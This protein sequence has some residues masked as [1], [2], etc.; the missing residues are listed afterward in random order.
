[1]FC[2]GPKR[3]DMFA[4]CIFILLKH[5][6]A[7]QKHVHT[8]DPHYWNARSLWYCRNHASIWDHSMENYDWPAA[9][10]RL[11]LL[12]LK[13]RSEC[14]KNG[15]SLPEN[16]F[17]LVLAGTVFFWHGLFFMSVGFSCD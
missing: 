1:M 15:S 16:S 10:I 13:Q 7:K 17:T 9:G 12:L 11:M 3:S 4:R 2:S 6:E 14:A 8:A 5:A